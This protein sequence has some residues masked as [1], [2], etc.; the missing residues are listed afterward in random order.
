[1]RD[2]GRDEVAG[3][4]RGHLVPLRFGQM[5]FQ[6]GARRALAEVG[7]EDRGQGETTPGPTTPEAVSLRRHR[8]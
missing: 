3:H 7:L 8:R 5:P 2:D 4:V 1:M 6:D